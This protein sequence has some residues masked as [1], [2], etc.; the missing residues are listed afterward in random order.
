MNAKKC[1]NLS[2]LHFN[3]LVAMAKNNHSL[4]RCRLNYVASIRTSLKGV[5]LNTNRN[6]TILF[7]LWKFKNWSN[8]SHQMFSTTATNNH[9]HQTRLLLFHKIEDV[10]WF[11]HQR[12]RKIVTMKV[13]Q[14]LNIFISRYCWCLF[15]H[16]VCRVAPW[17]GKTA[18]RKKN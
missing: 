4:S 2:L 18:K 6:R 11:D 5:Q 17:I 14:F 12:P 13:T 10:T 16:V 3:C 7:S 9:H 15:S 8:F 1:H